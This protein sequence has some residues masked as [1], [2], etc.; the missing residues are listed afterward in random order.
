MGLPPS[1]LRQGPSQLYWPKP[2]RMA[3]T[4]H[5]VFTSL[6]D[7]SNSIESLIYDYSGVELG[8]PPGSLA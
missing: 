3:G 8:E 1:V 4:S 5:Y 2:P 6:G 7:M